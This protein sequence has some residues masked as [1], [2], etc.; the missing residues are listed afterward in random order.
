[1]E[2]LVLDSSCL[3]SASYDPIEKVLQVTFKSDDTT[4]KYADVPSETWAGLQTADSVGN[5]FNTYI[6]NFYQEI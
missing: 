1:M 4:H 3:S 6:R 5:Y 2:E